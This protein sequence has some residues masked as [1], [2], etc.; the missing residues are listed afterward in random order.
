M[1][2]RQSQ[3]SFRVS[4]ASSVQLRLTLWYVAMMSFIILAV[5]GCLYFFSATFLNAASTERT[6]ETQLDQQSQ[7]FS[8]LYRQPLLRKQPLTSLHLLAPSQEIVLL[9]RPDG[10][11][12][13]VHSPLSSHVIQQ[14]QARVQEETVGHIGV[15]DEDVDLALLRFCR[16]FR[17]CSH[18]R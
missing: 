12:L 6:L 14:V 16:K 10:R 17:P 2:Q 4:L 8:A 18:I 5:G 9:L 1:K 7:H 3:Y 15:E 11:L 13:D